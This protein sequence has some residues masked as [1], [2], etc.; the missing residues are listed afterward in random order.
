MDLTLFHI[1]FS[2]WS[3]KARFALAHHGLRT[4]E[5]EY[6]PLFDEP[7]M[8][9]RLRKA[10]GRISVPVLLTPDGA[11]TDSWEIALYAD[12]VGSGPPLI[13]AA[14][15]AQ[16]ANWNAAS[17]RLLNAGR[18]RSMVRATGDPE[19]IREALPAPIRNLDALAVP[20]GR[21]GVRLFNRKYGIREGDLELHASAMRLELDH[22]QQALAGRSYV[23]GDFSYADVTMAFALQVIDPLPATPMAPAARRAS[24]DDELRRSYAELL[25]WRDRVHARHRLLPS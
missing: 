14:E 5:R 6:K 2:P 3:L 16:I 10:R 12:R 20:V 4:N 13:P 21:V 8:R 9:F 25:S 18:A 17:E 19:A 23:L 15:R 22:L 7:A 24:T 11:V 1:P